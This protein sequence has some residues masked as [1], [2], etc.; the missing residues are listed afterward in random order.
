MAETSGDAVVLVGETKVWEFLNEIR[1]WLPQIEGYVTH[2]VDSDGFIIVA[3]RG[4]VGFMTKQ[5]RLRIEVNDRRSDTLL[6]FSLIGLDDPITGFGEL[7]TR[8]MGESTTAIEYRFEM[9]AH[10]VASPVVNEF[11][12]RL[13]PSTIGQLAE[14]IAARLEDRES[15]ENP[16]RQEKKAKRGPRKAASP[17]ELSDST[18]KAAN[19]GPG[20]PKRW[21]GKRTWGR[22][23]TFDLV[24]VGCGGAGLTAAITAHDEGA[25][26]LILEKSRQVG[27]TFAYSTGLTWVPNNHHM[28][29]L[30]L[31]D[32]SENALRYVRGRTAGRHDEEVLQ[33]FIENAPR[34]IKYLEARGVPFQIVP[35][36]PDEQAEVEGGTSSGR[37]L[38]SPLFS[39]QSLGPDWAEALALSPQYGA[40]PVTWTEIQRWG[41]FGTI[42]D[43]DWNLIAERGAQ[44]L[45]AFGMSTAGFLLKAVLDRE[46]P[47]RTQ[48]SALGLLEQDGRIVGVEVEG[49]N[50]NKSI[51]ATHGVILA[52][53]GYDN[54]DELKQLFEP[55]RP[56]STTLGAPTV[57]GSGILMGMEHGARFS[58]LAGQLL[59]PTYKIPGEEK[60]GQPISRM[61]ARESG[62]PGSLLVNQSGHR[63]CDEANIT[64]L[65]RALPYLD[66]ESGTFPNLPAYFIFDQQ[67][68]DRYPLGSIMPGETPE[69]LLRAT[70]VQDLADRLDI[71]AATLERTFKEFNHHAADGAD[72]D[73]GRGNTAF[74]RSNGDPAIGPNPCLR[75]LE[76]PLYAIRIDIGTVGGNS[77]FVTSGDSQVK[78]LRGVPIP[79]LYA[80]GNTSANLVGGLWYNAGLMN[81]RGMTFAHLAVRHAL[82]H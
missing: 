4:R 12:D 58:V 36:Y 39:S 56:P 9:R 59:L 67:W 3:M 23:E 8:N 13:V 66:L 64:E 42:A 50:I 65:R 33:A 14:R 5:T 26:V 62:F 75:A 60:D 11:L 38:C 72:P 55:S 2:E 40:L 16:P 52:T 15:S 25:S 43:W 1:N 79:G 32:S 22:R 61:L 51:H 74:S 21:I 19:A 68:K 10:G 80:A 18:R 70:R 54:N 71:P 46:I 49:P 6:R 30:D 24:V 53:G 73:F 77:G 29:D 17:S 57:D 7:V 20:R 45:R 63:F 47:I 69:W 28:P 76:P 48:T 78:S 37:Y 34:V 44:G 81:A 27:G 31:I 35:N 41:G 82:A